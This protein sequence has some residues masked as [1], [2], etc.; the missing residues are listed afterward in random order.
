MTD[1]DPR[2]WSEVKKL[3]GERP[4]VFD[5]QLAGDLSHGAE[6]V[7]HLMSCYKFASKMIG[8][9]KRVLDVGCGEGLGTW[10]L[11]KECG[12]AEGLD[13]DPGVISRAGQNWEDPRISFTCREP[14]DLGKGQ[15]DAIVL[16]Q[17]IGD[18]PLQAKVDLFAKASDRLVHDGILV[19]GL[20]GSGE[21]SSL[22]PGSDDQRDA[23]LPQAW[24]KNEMR[25]YFK[26]VFMF[27]ANDEIIHVWPLPPMNHII[28][29]G[30]RKRA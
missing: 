7:L 8:S 18:S 30:C 16:F 22:A 28:A 4:V 10:L 12:C 15:W 11:A 24:L 6:H 14:D 13:T 26:H 19:A 29:L 1:G 9:G 2:G 23:I 3:L 25:R 20:F 21:R 5:R 17:A 27:G